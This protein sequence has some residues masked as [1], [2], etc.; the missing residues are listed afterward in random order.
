M[1]ATE[2]Q[3]PA[4][5][6][7]KPPVE[8]IA[9]Q[10]T[11]MVT[12]TMHAAMKN[13]PRS[14]QA[15]PGPSEL[16]IPCTRRLAYK[17]LDWPQPNSDRDQWLSTIGTA[18]HSWQADVF[19]AANRELGRE[20]FLVER[21]VQLPFGISGSSDLYDRDIAA[22]V[23]WK[24]TSLDSIRR[25]RRSGPG[26]QYRVQAHLYGLGMLLAGERPQHVADVF[27]PRGGLLDGLWIWT[28]P[29]S[30]KVAAD[31]LKR[32]DATR[33]ALIMLDPE[34]HPER[35]ALFPTAPAYCEWCPFYLP[36][37]GDLSQG[38]PGHRTVTSS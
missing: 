18:V 4:A 14:Q 20:R 33:T 11:S 5:G 23:D 24:V 28:E 15:A 7:V 12:E 9:G 29:F 6:W 17:I 31:A 21:R 3:Q 32:Y 8:G 10:L 37:S 25:Y 26:Q 2:F 34:K 38:C 30:P 27:L 35:W 13:H 1:I 16:G 36:R 22:V 19:E